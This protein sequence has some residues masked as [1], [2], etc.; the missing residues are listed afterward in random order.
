M[1]EI[2][3]A[4]VPIIE[5]VNGVADIAASKTPIIANE[6]IWTGIVWAVLAALV[7][8]VL[9]ALSVLWFRSIAN[10]CPEDMPEDSGPGALILLLVGVGLFIGGIVKAVLI[11]L[12]P[13]TYVL[14]EALNLL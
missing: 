3:E 12:A 14:R 5:K 13:N 9:S 7:G 2:Q 6:M 8:M 4:I 10:A 11:W 1:S